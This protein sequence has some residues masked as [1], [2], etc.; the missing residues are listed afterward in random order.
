MKLCEPLVEEFV[1]E[2]AATRKVLER[3]PTEKFEWQP[4]EKSMPMGRLA[5]HVAD[6]AGWMD[7]TLNQNELNVDS[8]GL[9]PF[10]ATST[11]DLVKTFDA[12]VAKSKEILAKA[13]DELLMEN[14]KMIA[15]GNAVIDTAK[16]TVV[17][18]WI[19]NHTIHH[20][21]QLTVYLRLNDIPVPS[22]YG[23]S[24]DEQPFG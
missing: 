5:S 21:A 16:I 6:L 4:H 14:W 9:T 7:F 10:A 17:R 20:R 24:A 13:S 11:D 1:Q 15:G 19:L 23:P 8:G 12:N 2:A 18:I 3:V 22:I